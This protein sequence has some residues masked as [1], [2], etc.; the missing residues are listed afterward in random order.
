MATPNRQCAIL[1]FGV[2][3]KPAVPSQERQMR[4]KGPQSCKSLVAIL[5]LVAIGLGI[6][7]AGARQSSAPRSAGERPIETDN[8]AAAALH[9][10]PVQGNVY[11]LV[12]DGANVAAQVGED[13][14][15]LVDS[16]TAALSDNLVQTVQSEFHKP[17]RYII[18]SNVLPDHAG[19]NQNVGKRGRR[20]DAPAGNPG[21]P[22]AILGS[23]AQIIAFQSV[24]DRMSDSKSQDYVAAE[25]AWP[26]DAYED[27]RKPL[28]FNGEAI[29]ILHQPAANTDGDTMV[30][31]RASD[32]VTTG[33]IFSTSSY[34]VIDLQRGGSLQGVID[35]LNRLMYQITV[36]GNHQE[37]GTM[38][39]PGHGRLCDQGDL[40]FYQEMVTVIRD[41]IQAM[42][43][44][45]MTLEQVKAA[46]PTMDY[47]PRYAGK[48]AWTADMFVEAAYKS[49][50]EKHE[51]N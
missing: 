31:F 34:P 48:G 47:D 14:V 51:A 9:V 17:I 43:K 23:G 30:L 39:I 45:G 36:T 22:I 6:R 26:N 38:I 19:G 37:G 5:V 12:G 2:K 25:E 15:L 42:I 16:G 29:D 1:N 44:R 4:I 3:K 18:D 27:P 28:H 32:V 11:M 21:N 24:L 41:R 8:G 10:L 33:D 13:G 7:V 49:L 35:G 20:Y 40:S 46:K 50:S